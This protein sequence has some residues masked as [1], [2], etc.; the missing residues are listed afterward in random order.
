[1]TTP[2]KTRVTKRDRPDPQRLH[3]VTDKLNGSLL[4][5]E[6]ALTDL[7]LGV[8]AR[9]TLHD[10]PENGWSSELAFVKRGGEFRLVVISGDYRD[11][12]PD[13]TPI[14]NASR[15]T[16]L[17]AVDLLPKLYEKLIDSFEAEIVRVNESIATVEELA[18]AIRA[19]AGLTAK[20]TE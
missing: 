15:E 17:E 13:I 5:M 20:G 16:R 8:S 6:K 19:K 9:V 3:S 2:G 1:M 4:N 11:D 14:T 7:N 10:D 12:D 18:E